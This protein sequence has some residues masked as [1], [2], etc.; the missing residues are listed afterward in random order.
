MS[1]ISGIKEERHDEAEIRELAAKMVEAN[2]NKVAT[3]QARQP[4]SQTGIVGYFPKKNDN[5]PRAAV[6]EDRKATDDE[7]VRGKFGWEQ[8]GGKRY[9]PYIFRSGEK[10]CAVRMVEMKLINRFL[11]HLHQDIY[12]CTCIRSYY[13]TEAESRLLNEINIKH[14]DNQFGRDQFTPRDLIVRLCDANE[15]YNFLE[16]CYS[17]LMHGSCN[18][19]DRCGFIRIN[20]ESVV[21]YT[22]KNDNKYV[23]LF[24]FEGETENLKMKADQLEGWD[25]SYLKFCCK[26]Q[27]IR[28]ELFAHDSCAVISLNAIKSYF[29]PGTG[30]EDYWPSKVVE[31]QLLLNG[32]NPPQGGTQMV[33]GQW[34]RQPPTPPTMQKAAAPAKVNPNNIHHQQHAAHAMQPNLQHVQALY[35]NY[36]G[37]VGGQPTYQNIPVSQSS[38]QAVRMAQSP[39]RASYQSPA[40]Q[41]PRA[42]VGHQYYPPPPLTQAPPPLVRSGVPPSSGNAQTYTTPS[43]AQNVMMIQDMNGLAQQVNTYQNAPRSN[44]TPNPNMNMGQRFPPPPLIPVRPVNGAQTAQRYHHPFSNNAADAV[45]LSA[46]NMTRSVLRAAMPEENHLNLTSGRTSDLGKKLTPIAETPTSG[47]HIPYKLQ[48]ALVEG[49]MIHCINMKP[50]V[51][52]EL[53]VTLPDIINH[54]FNTVPL[55]NCRRAMVLLG[56]EL[57]RGNRQ[58]MQILRESGKCNDSNDN[59]PLVQVHDVIKFMP[60]MKYMLGNLPNEQPLSKRQ[61][62][63]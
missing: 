43:G 2:K 17:K 57:Y 44:L 19:K 28:N 23:P 10:Y 18:P 11:N 58:Q 63:S 59:L 50:Y 61:R 30:F 48:K 54:F 4:A 14:C 16:I 40:P 27:G 45:D 21:P 46:N 7:S 13:I 37:L 6:P 55:T 49:K 42:G 8:F 51:W 35:P 3:N 1:S 47:T 41:S 56:I 20:K 34:T 9:I 22:V 29:P 39:A 38:G 31:S 53:L 5:K 15:F 36:S 24:Y 33:G 60:Q 25:L 52:T 26:V 12:S 32:K 62:T